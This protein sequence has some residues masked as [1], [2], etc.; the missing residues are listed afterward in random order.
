MQISAPWPGAGNRKRPSRPQAFI[1]C[2]NL[3]YDAQRGNE[4]VMN[5]WLG[6]HND[7]LVNAPFFLIVENGR[8]EEVVGYLQEHP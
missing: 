2:Y 6:Q 1:C 8:L 7:A 5:N 4:V 3:L